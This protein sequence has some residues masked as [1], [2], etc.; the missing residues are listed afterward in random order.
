MEVGYCV[1]VCVVTVGG[2]VDTGLSV[3]AGV[4]VGIA[5]LT[6]TTGVGVD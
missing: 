3:G 5:S 1:D 4:S 2:V 6:T